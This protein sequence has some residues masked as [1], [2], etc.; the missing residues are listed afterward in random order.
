MRENFFCLYLS[1][2]ECFIVEENLKVIVFWDL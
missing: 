2:I 1:E